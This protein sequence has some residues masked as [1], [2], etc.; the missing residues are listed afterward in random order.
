MS[1]KLTVFRSVL[2]WESLVTL[3]TLVSLYNDSQFD[4]DGHA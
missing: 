4:I 1:V 2:L 3:V